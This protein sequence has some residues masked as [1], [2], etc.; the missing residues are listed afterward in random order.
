MLPP[1][2]KRLTK[3]E[4]ADI[5]GLLPCLLEG[6]TAAGIGALVGRGE[7][8]V[9]RL[10]HEHGY[11]FVG[12]NQ[13]GH[14]EYRGEKG[15]HKLTRTSDE[16]KAKIEELLP[17]LLE[18]WTPRQIGKALG[19]AK[20]V[21]IYIAERSGYHYVGT[22]RSGHWE[23]QGGNGDMTPMDTNETFALRALEADQVTSETAQSI[24]EYEAMVFSDRTPRQREQT[25]GV[26]TLLDI[27]DADEV[28][29][30]IAEAHGLIND[31]INMNETKAV[32]VRELQS[33]CTGLQERLGDADRELAILRPKAEELE[34]IKSQRRRNEI[35]QS[36]GPLRKAIE[37]AKAYLGR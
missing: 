7:S 30:R 22:N 2:G 24:E 5:V 6:S 13:T 1:R 20:H 33:V 16:M 25:N 37:D 10:A 18:G 36:L 26:P 31:L 15:M 28:K 35:Q 12:L 21:V 23:Y 32:Q 27:E 9:R 8:V 29:A 11:V 34:S 4:E 3:E 17:R 14:W 19:V